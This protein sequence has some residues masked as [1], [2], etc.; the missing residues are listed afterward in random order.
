[1]K[2]IVL[3]ASSKSETAEFPERIISGIVLARSAEMNND[4]SVGHR[5][6]FFSIS[7]TPCLRNHS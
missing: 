3:V 6:L 5:Q 1:M 7:P 2:Q 4:Y